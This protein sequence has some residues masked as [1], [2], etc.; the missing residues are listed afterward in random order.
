MF[1]FILFMHC[2]LENCRL[3]FMDMYVLEVTKELFFFICFDRH[4]VQSGQAQNDRGTMYAQNPQG[5]EEKPGSVKWMLSLFSTPA[6]LL[7]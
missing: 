5:P 7:V 6:A 4:R 3:F 1:Y 2:C